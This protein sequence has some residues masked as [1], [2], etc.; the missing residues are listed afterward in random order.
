MLLVAALGSRSP[1]ADGRPQELRLPPDATYR[2][3]ETT[4]P[5]PVVF[6]HATHVPLTDTRCVTCHPAPFSILQPA[7]RI[8]HEEMNS[9]Q[10]C[11]ACHNGTKASG[12]EDN[13]DHCHHT[14]GGS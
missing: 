10:K 11:G 1:A 8:T 9:G 2:F 3:F 13:C 14:G 12:V 7:G 6:S 5:G 4:A